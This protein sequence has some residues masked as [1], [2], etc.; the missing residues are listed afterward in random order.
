MANLTPMVRTEYL[1]GVPQVGPYDEILNTDAHE[2]G[3]S[4]V[5]NLGRAVAEPVASHG[6]PASLTLT[7]PP[8]GMV[9][10][11]PATGAP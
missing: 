3:G 1:V 9:V 4:G 7:L 10:L 11:T 5:G 6:H 2:Y 8:L